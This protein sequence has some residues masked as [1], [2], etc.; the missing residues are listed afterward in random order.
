MRVCWLMVRHAW[1]L[2]L[3]VPQRPRFSLLQP[4]RA[5]PQQ[6]H[7]LSLYDDGAVVILRLV[8]IFQVDAHLW[9]CS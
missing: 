5:L 7:L 1:L 3:Q 2:S 6:V 9:A 4:R 8:H